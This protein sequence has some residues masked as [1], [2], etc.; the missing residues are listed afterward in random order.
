MPHGDLTIRTAVWPEDIPL[1]STLLHDYQA[2]LAAH[3]PGVA[4]TGLQEELARGLQRWT[5]PSGVMVLAFVEGQPAGCVCLLV[6]HDRLQAACELKRLWVQPGIRGGGVGRAMLQAAIAWCRHQGAA[7]VLLDTL[8]QAMPQAVAL[9]QSA[10][11][12]VTERHNTSDIPGLLFM[13][14]DLS[15]SS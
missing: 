7:E 14:L 9:Y 13:K 12:V 2:F 5:P 4:V 15:T 3:T 1:A 10:G 6:R 11:F 8:P